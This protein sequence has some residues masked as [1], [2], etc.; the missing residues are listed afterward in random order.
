MGRA[1]RAASDLIRL[2]IVVLIIRGVAI[3]LH[4]HYVGKHGA[5]SVVLICVEEET[6]SLELVCV[7]EDVAWLRALFG[8]P[9]CEAIPVE[10]AL[11]VD[12]EL[13]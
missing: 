1:Y 7:A 10:V 6:E 3:A 13:E 4:G 11:A 5:W 9:H 8:E 12:L 2:A